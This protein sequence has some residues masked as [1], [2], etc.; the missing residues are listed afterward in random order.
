MNILITGVAGFIGSNLAKSLVNDGHTLYGIDNFSY[1]KKENIAELQSNAQFNFTEGDIRDPETLNGFDCD[2]LVHLASQKI[3]RYSNALVTLNDNSLMVKN[4][5][6]TCVTDNI[7]LVFASTSDVYGKN[8][9]VPYTEESDLLLGPTTIKRWAYA[10]SK[11]FSEQLLI[12]NHDEFDLTYVIC[13]FFGSYG[14]NQ[15]LTWWGGPQ[16]VFIEKAIKKE[17]MDLH[18]DGTQTRTF[19]YI[20]DLVDGITRCIVNE[21][22]NNQ[23]FNIASE[24]TEEIAIADLAKMIWGKINGQDS[25]PMINFVPYATFGNYEDVMR[26]V[27][28]INKIKSALGYQPNYNLSDGLDLA[29][30]WQKTQY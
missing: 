17:A 1:G 15:N 6:N 7:K 30:E 8:P 27:P 12:A 2:V 25:E 28:S 10:T 13:R 16:S 4:V 21:K 26:R 3:P 29:I 19:T 22:A 20:D 14:P 23:I 11:I 5:I 24:P 18:G 9:N